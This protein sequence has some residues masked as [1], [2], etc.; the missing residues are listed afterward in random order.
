MFA[1]SPAGELTRWKTRNDN[2]YFA[3]RAKSR[4]TCRVRSNTH[5][6]HR[7]NFPHRNIAWAMPRIS[8]LVETLTSMNERVFNQ[9]AE[10]A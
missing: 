2:A 6:R 5:P 7:G 9:A 4:G 8:V 10:N 3:C 1:T